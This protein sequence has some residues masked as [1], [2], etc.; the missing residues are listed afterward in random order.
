MRRSL[1]LR[2]EL[3]RD[4]TIE[5]LKER[6]ED[7]KIEASRCFSYRVQEFLTLKLSP[8]LRRVQE[9]QGTIEKLRMENKRLESSSRSSAMN[10][11]ETMD[12]KAS[13]IALQADKRRLGE[14]LEGLRDKLRWFVPLPR[15]SHL[16]SS[17]CS[18]ACPFPY[19]FPSLVQVRREP[20][21]A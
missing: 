21:V 13:L 7:D 5:H 8:P 12:L 14:E 3:D 18:T 16:Y 9:L 11:M 2:A 10:A 1:D 17:S 20:A 15:P 4:A 19:P 6:L